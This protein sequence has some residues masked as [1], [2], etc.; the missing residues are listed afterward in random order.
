[1]LDLLRGAPDIDELRKALQERDAEIEQLQ[2]Q[3]KAHQ[4][5]DQRDFLNDNSDQLATI[6]S[7]KNQVIQE[8]QAQ[9]RI[10]QEPGAA[11]TGVDTAQAL[12]QALDSARTSTAELERLRAHV[13][14]L[15][16]EIHSSEERVQ[17][18]EKD[19][20]KALGKLQAAKEQ[21][22]QLQLYRDENNRQA[23]ELASSAAQSAVELGKLQAALKTATER[24]DHSEA[25]VTTLEQ[26]LA[27]S[28]AAA[29]PPGVAP[30]TGTLPGASAH[31]A[32]EI[33][34]LQDAILA[35]REALRTERE[36]SAGLEAQLSAAGSAAAETKQLQ[37][38]VVHARN[39]LQA[40]RE[41]STDLEAQLSSGETKHLEELRLLQARLEESEQAAAREVELQ[42]ALDTREAQ[43]AKR[44]QSIAAREEQVKDTLRGAEAELSAR[45]A[46]LARREQAAQ[47]QE[48][49]LSSREA[50]VEQRFR[51]AEAAAPAALVSSVDSAERLQSL[52]A[53]E[54]ASAER[55]AE[56]ERAIAEREAALSE[57]EEAAR[58]MQAQG[59]A[60]DLKVRSC[61]QAEIEEQKQLLEEREQ[62]LLKQE[63]A[64][65]EREEQQHHKN[66]VREE[67]DAHNE[68]RL[69]ERELVIDEREQLLRQR[70]LA[71]NEVQAPGQATSPIGA[72]VAVLTD[73]VSQLTEA[74]ERA[75][76]SERLVADRCDAYE[77]EVSK[78][79]RQFGPEGEAGRAQRELAA[80]SQELQASRAEAVEAR[81]SA[82][83]FAVKAQRLEAQLS[84]TRQE[85]EASQQR[86]AQVGS[87][88]VPPSTTA[89]LGSGGVAG[90]IAAA[91][92][93][94]ELGERS[95]VT[96][97][98][99]GL[100]DISGL[101]QADRFLQLLSA[102]MA[103]RADA[104]LTVFGLWILCHLIYVVYLFY[105][106]LVR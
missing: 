33:K 5:A 15:E 12:A 26:Q 14:T 87:K 39:E 20:D 68:R 43:I 23:A 86:L 74:L 89:M 30:P 40:E 82:Q 88:G 60:E 98:D 34:A 85:Q 83:E 44:E 96:I 6:I 16:S 67:A 10:F 19:R 100:S 13:L 1:M 59:Q 105:A 61:F 28:P 36:R 69:R 78:L 51:D 73:T 8:L 17:A 47:A 48:A 72:K 91:L 11:G 31:E 84:R 104:R 101:P 38:A 9:L 79:K 2:A 95:G 92:Q 41:R 66:S 62:A 32:G 55:C 37:D 18:A 94:V 53:Q 49:E 99:L 24:A 50:F 52:E 22:S 25:K 29:A 64:L 63:R 76:E 103:V 106:H 57:L 35:A 97:I 80:A 27:V 21:Q 102:L 58:Q 46:D 75:R 90:A 42:S 56:R 93:D 70:E 77:A 4:E 3:L 7:T 45:D 81:R 65:E 54:R 71:E